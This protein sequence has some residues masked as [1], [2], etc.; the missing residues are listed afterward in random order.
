[1]VGLTLF[2]PLNPA[3]HLPNLLYTKSPFVLDPIH[4]SGPVLRGNGSRRAQSLKKEKKKRKAAPRKRP[5]VVEP[6][7]I[8]ARIL[9]LQQALWCPVVVAAPNA[10]DQLVLSEGVLHTST[11]SIMKRNSIESFSKTVIGARRVRSVGLTR[12]APE[13]PEYVCPAR[14]KTPQKSIQQAGLPGSHPL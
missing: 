4:E 11:S 14:R 3:S 8:D 7:E 12:V 2:V 13:S 9:P 10:S 6:A 5:V 1:V